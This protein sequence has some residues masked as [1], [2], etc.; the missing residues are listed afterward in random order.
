MLQTRMGKAI[1]F[2]SND[3]NSKFIIAETLCGIDWE[4]VGEFTNED[5]ASD[6]NR[7]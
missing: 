2:I 5:Y 3:F 7:L 6:V 4:S 1:H